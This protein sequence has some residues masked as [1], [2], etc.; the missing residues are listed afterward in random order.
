MTAAKKTFLFVCLILAA[1]TVALY[2]PVTSHPFIIFD[3]TEYVSANPHVTS[4]LSWTNLAWAFHGAHAANWHPLT[5]VSHQ[6]DC[7]LFGQ[8]AGRHHLVN[9]LFH[10]ANTL[11]VF[12]FLRRATGALWRSA[13]VAALFAWHPLHVESVA[14]ASERKDTLST[15]FFLLTL[16]AY[17]RYVRAR[18][19]AD[20]PAAAAS[21]PSR[22][23]FHASLPYGAAL[24]WF[25]L[26]LM[27]KPMVVTLPFVLLLLDFWP[28]KRISTR[29]WAP[30]NYRSLLLE[31]V[32]FFALMIAGSLATYLAQSGAGAVWYSPWSERLAN[33]VLAYARYVAKTFW[34]S[35]LALVYSH[36]QHSPMLLA[37]GAAALLTVWTWLC[38]RRWRQS[39]YL[40]V[41]WFWFVGTLVPT[42]GLVQVGAQ[43]MA[44][45]YT[46]IPSLG[47][48]I[49]IVWGGW[50]WLANRPRGNLLAALLAGCA[51]VG[52]VLATTLQIS[53]W[54][55]DISLFLH[56]V[57]STQDNYVADN[58]LGKAFEL[59]G[60]K[61]YA[62][63]LYRQAVELE[64]RY[65]QS[66]FNLAM[67]L[68]EFGKPDEALGHLQ[69]AAGLDP[70]N[71]DIRFDLGIFYCQHGNPTNAVASFNET[72]RLRPGFAPAFS[73]LGQAYAQLGEFEKAAVN[74]REALRLQPD[75]EEAKKLLAT[76][77]AAHPELH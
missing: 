61:D 71:A 3:D 17:L 2:W 1:G 68:L 13:L 27:S 48:F 69:T 18:A 70:S 14:W 28:L 73:W 76:L 35:D 49:A 55:S 56:A 5:W 39:P 59:A 26:G 10:V 38:L 20:A 77:L 60:K 64:P 19:V 33:A 7:T 66:Q 31:K 50:E 24:F 12:I 21:A 16:I 11:L 47:F 63:V 57:E 25:A 67:S 6:L 54:R 41:G 8:N 42:I 44:D 75:F 46:Y 22:L 4:G 36:P 74:Y 65:P 32:P 72:L 43:S 53:Y 62:L 37:L 23:T 15:L 34:P 52:C 9:V 45:R 58:C 51:L 40:A 29:Q 30:A